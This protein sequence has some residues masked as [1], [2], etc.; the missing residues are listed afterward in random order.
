MLVLKTAYTCLLFFQQ[1]ILF[2][3]LAAMEALGFY[4]SFL[5]KLLIEYIKKRIF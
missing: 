2:P 3:K 1:Y 4:R 5:R